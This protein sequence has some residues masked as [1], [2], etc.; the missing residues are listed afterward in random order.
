MVA[1][2]RVNL[3]GLDCLDIESYLCLNMVPDAADFFCDDCLIELL[4]LLCEICKDLGDDASCLLSALIVRSHSAS[5]SLFASVV[6]AVA[7][8]SCCSIFA[9]TSRSTA[10]LN[11]CVAKAGSSN[12]RSIDTVSM[13][14]GG[15][16]IIR[17]ALWGCKHA[18]CQRHFKAA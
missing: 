4:G 10:E 13:S 3:R 2:C 6:I 12:T 8:A 7:L 1:L 17:F 9:L 5:A 16:W 11:V 18:H 15:C 14:P